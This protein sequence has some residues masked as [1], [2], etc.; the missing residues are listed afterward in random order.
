MPEPRSEWGR[1]VVDRVEQLATK[2]DNLAAEVQKVDSA[3][4]E[5]KQFAAEGRTL[6]E[7][8]VRLDTQLGATVKA[9]DQ[10]TQEMKGIVAFKTTGENIIGWI[11]WFFG[12]SLAAGVTLLLALIASVVAG[13][14]IRSSVKWQGQRIDKLE[15]ATVTL[16]ESTAKLQESTSNNAM[17]T[18]SLVENL[19]RNTMAT[20]QMMADMGQELKSLP[21]VKPDFTKTHEVTARFS[22]TKKA[23]KKKEYGSI[24][25]DLELTDP[26][27]KDKVEKTKVTARLAPPDR[28]EPSPRFANV[29]LRAGLRSEGRFCWVQI[30]L[31]ET[32]AHKL[33]G[34]LGKDSATV[35]VDITFT[36][37]D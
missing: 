13:I 24:V 35:P 17:A 12:G 18:R 28:F 23:I 2:V 3:M 10:L 33:E 8:A 36:I 4:T 20:K 32:E 6:S 37:P 15:E 21:L 5:L 22:L 27:K 16:Q 26:I 19:E 25:F 9:L 30:F 31:K 1:E 34:Y 14:E 7:T 29:Q 11:K